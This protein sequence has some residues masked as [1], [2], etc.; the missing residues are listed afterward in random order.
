MPATTQNYAPRLLKHL[1][2]NMKRILIT[3]ARAPVAID[4][5]RRFHAAGHSVFLCDSIL[6]PI[7]RFTK[8]KAAFYRVPS[9][10]HNTD[11]FI[12]ELNRIIDQQ[13]IDLL[14]P[15]SEEAFYVSAHQDQL[16]CQALIDSLPLLDS[17]HNKFTFSQN[18]ENEFASTPRTDLISNPR[19][20]HMYAP[21]AKQFVFKPVYSRFAASAL[22]GPSTRRLSNL[23]FDPAQ[24]WIA[25]E[26]IEGQEICSFSLADKGRLLAH[27]SYAAPYRAG[28]GG[29]IFF[30]PHE[31]FGILNYV[32]SF[33]R[34]TN[35][36]GQI[37]F[38]FIVDP[39]D[40]PWVIECNPRATSGIHLFA[41]DK[42]L[43]DAYLS[44]LDPPTVADAPQIDEYADFVPMQPDVRMI[45]AA[46]PFWGGIQAIMQLKPG[47][48]IRDFRSANDALTTKDDR[49]PL[50]Y[51]P[52]T[53]A[54]LC[55][56]ALQKFHSLQAASTEDMEWNGEGLADEILN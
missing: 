43:C 15:T 30:E 28:Q 17:L 7:G 26:K 22:I 35:F 4:L 3:G 19:Q 25:Q 11:G 51:F 31:H 50:Y 53:M 54:E 20:L 37:G 36:S 8:Q 9:P 40:H 33:L 47:K 48:F 27:A 24:T 1:T 55:F 2:L 23:Y 41:S 39:E 42:R 44:V 38:D 13:Q 18:Y 14:I 45:G 49:N 32:E 10:R 12:D 46:M 29:G 34:E 16:H 21:Q 56:N 52:L 6:F 5:S